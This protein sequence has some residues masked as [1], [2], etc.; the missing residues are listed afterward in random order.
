MKLKSNEKKDRLLVALEGAMG[1]VSLACE[2]AR[3]SRS[4]YYDY[5]NSDSEF[6]KRVDE[7]SDIA[8]DFTESQLL[9]L[10]EKGNPQAIMFYLKTKG[11][12]RGYSER[13]EIESGGVKPSPVI[14]YLPN[15]Q[16]E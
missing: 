11:K 13:V 15:N 14:I 7:L 12:K 3:V 10:I 8:L 2:K 4:T 6:A 9:K 16:R 1:I 5:Y